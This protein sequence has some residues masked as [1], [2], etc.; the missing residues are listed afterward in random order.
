MKNSLIKLGICLCPLIV[1]GA[2]DIVS[3]VTVS[4]GEIRDFVSD[5]ELQ[6]IEDLNNPTQERVVI[7]NGGDSII[8]ARNR[9]ILKPGFRAY[10]GSSVW[11]A[12]DADMDGFSDSE[13]MVDTENSGQGDGMFD[14]WEDYYGLNSSIDD[15]GSDLDSDGVSNLIEFKMYFD[16][17]T[18]VTSTPASGTPII[19]EI[20]SPGK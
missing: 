5:D 14:A 20:T 8:W 3:D 4:N 6:T 17:S 9:V 16:P 13:S 19:F 7:Q 1:F 18:D 2:A 10:Y 11:V 15:S 12:T